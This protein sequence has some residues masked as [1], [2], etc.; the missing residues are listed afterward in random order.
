MR[1]MLFEAHQALIA[2]NAWL[3]QRLRAVEVCENRGC[4]LFSLS[5]C[6]TLLFCL[7]PLC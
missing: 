2:S 3:V 5:C 6:P 7:V 4:I 1:T